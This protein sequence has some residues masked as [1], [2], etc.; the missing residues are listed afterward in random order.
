MKRTISAD[1]SEFIG[2]NGT[3]QNPAAMSRS[4]L[5]GRVGAALDPCAAIQVPFDLAYGAE[6][7]IVFT[8]GVGQDIEDAR[9]LV[10]RFVVDPQGRMML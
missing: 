2:R 1:R 8:L 4:H 5:S 6:R 3:I 7:E 10:K 9:N